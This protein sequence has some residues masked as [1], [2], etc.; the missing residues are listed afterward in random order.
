ML[1]LMHII[2]E[3]I[4]PEDSPQICSGGM[5]L[6]DLTTSLFLSNQKNHTA[7]FSLSDTGTFVK[8]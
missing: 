8:E 7:R 2:P 3:L 1:L 5:D 6:M 4:S